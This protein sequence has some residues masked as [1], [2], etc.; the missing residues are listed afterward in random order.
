MADVENA[1]P[2]A[3]AS[4]LA[5]AAAGEES[6]LNVSLFYSRCARLHSYFLKNRESLFNG[7]SSLSLHRGAIDEDSPYAKSGCVQLFL[8]GYNIPD[9]VMTLAAD[10][11]VCFLGTKKK[12]AFL[13]PLASK[14]QGASSAITVTLLERNKD[15]GNLANFGLIL[16]TM[17]GAPAKTVGAL[18]KDNNSSSFIDSYVEALEKGGHGLVDSGVGVSNFLAVKEAVEAETVKKAAVLTNKIFKQSFIPAMEA[19]IDEGKL[20]SHEKM[21]EVVSA[22][23]EDPS[24]IKL[25]VRPEDVEAC[26][27][28]IIQSGGKY[29]LKVSA[30]SNK[31]DMKFDVIIA[32]IGARY[33]NYCSSMSR[34]FLVDPPA[35]VS[36]NYDLLVELQTACLSVMKPGNDLSSV[37]SEAVSFLKAKK[38]DDLVSSLPKNLGFAIGLDFRDNNLILNTKNTTM[39]RANQVFHLSLGF[40]DIALDDADLKDVS[41]KSDVKKLKNYSLLI[42]DTFIVKEIDVENDDGSDMPEQ[43]TK[44]SKEV[45][46]VVYTINEKGSDEESEEED[47]DDDDS[48]ASGGDDDDDDKK[49]K[50]KSSSS[51]NEESGRKSRRLAE[52]AEAG[53]ETAES[54]VLRIKQQAEL[55]KKKN[56]LRLREIARKNRKGGDANDEEAEAQEL[57]TYNSTED[58][59]ETVL[60]NQV[61]VDMKSECVILPIS[62]NPVPFHIS[63]IKNVVMP[64]PD[65]AHYLRINFHSAGAALGKDVPPNLVKLIEKHSPY[66]TFIREM[67]FRS[68]DSANLTDAYRK[69]MELRKRVKQRDQKEAEESDLVEQAK[70][71]RLKDGKIPR[72]QDITMRPVFGGRKTIGTLEA[73]ENGFRF[74]SNRGEQLD[75]IY[76]NIKNA[77]YQPCE[78]EIMVLVH[79]NLKNPIMI[80][81]KKHENVQFFTEV[82]EASEQVDGGR[83]SMYD[84]DEMD[85][86]QRQRQLR[87]KLNEAYKDF[88]KKVE[89][90][91]KKFSS[92]SSGSGIEFDI[93]YRD[94]GFHGTPN[95]EMVFVQPTVNCLV[96][97][98]ETPFFCVD[99]EKV[100]HVHFERITFASKAFDIVLINKDFT[101][102]PWRCDMIDNKDKDAIQEWLTDMEITYTE[103]PINL[104]WKTVM[105]TAAQEPRFYEDTE[106]DGTT[107]KDA[108]WG[109]LRP[110]DEGAEGDLDDDEDDSEFSDAAGED[111]ESDASDD[112]SDEE[113]D[114]DDEESE[115]SDEDGDE[116]LEEEGMD[117]DDMEKEAAEDDKRKAREQREEESGQ[118]SQKRQKR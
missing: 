69:I 25:K 37:Y 78:R 39:F 41:V 81:K 65:V 10:G 7:A 91:S 115:S 52:V 49:K 51:N 89:V 17:K 54:A 66:A 28:P 98:T 90:V 86:E 80:G 100:D 50:K 85:E 20:V 76:D 88:C 59:P 47:D 4:S 118:R 106:E 74:R 18:V 110:E 111:E 71:V 83:K 55:L 57:M 16:A 35:V 64:D 93:P 48:S 63:T 105:A 87:K 72:L 92:G 27:F 97:L 56:E 34:T 13:Q 6:G 11:T 70:L 45:D 40:Q 104:A 102:M 2:Q 101:K 44:A 82:V 109:I 29:D 116:D 84:P 33:Q 108:G 79:F 94:L 58:Y 12:I 46:D 5:G 1:P 117:W 75:I 32:S 60:P 96:N 42:A 15:D 36:K 95:K 38:R 114:F 8:F 9:L 43:L 68:L 22:V 26:Y 107:P 53:A 67:T 62:G 99:L 31:E 61:K 14:P 3:T 103:G 19:T 30:T 24:L 23:I 73:H 112:M 21:A 77:L 113:S